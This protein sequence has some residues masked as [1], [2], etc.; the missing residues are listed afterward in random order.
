MSHGSSMIFKVGIIESSLLAFKD[1]G[2]A[3][4][5]SVDYSF[6]S[7]HQMYC[8]YVHETASYGRFKKSPFFLLYFGLPVH[9]LESFFHDFIFLEQF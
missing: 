6:P 1:Y 5:N 4:K 7:K 9:F 2:K 8:Y 3:Q